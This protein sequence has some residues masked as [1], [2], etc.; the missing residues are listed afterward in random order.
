MLIWVIFLSLLESRTPTHT[1][2]VTG[3]RSQVTGHVSTVLL[4]VYFPEDFKTYAASGFPGMKGM[5]LKCS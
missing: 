1:L 5:G 3:H 4:S 2:H